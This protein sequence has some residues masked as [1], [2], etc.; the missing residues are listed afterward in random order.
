MQSAS[1]ARAP[2]SSMVKL[3]VRP[4][5]HETA[6]RRKRPRRRIASA[7]RLLC[8]LPSCQIIAAI[9]FRVERSTLQ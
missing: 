5:P 1:F 4:S 8:I 2:R 9:E 3:L 6:E 7:L